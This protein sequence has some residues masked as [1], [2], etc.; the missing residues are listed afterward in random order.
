MTLLL[1]TANYP[2]L[3]LGVIT[4]FH[5]VFYFQGHASHYTI[6]DILSLNT[7]T[8]KGQHV[9]LWK[10]FRNHRHGLPRAVLKCDCCFETWV[11][12]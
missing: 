8:F 10:N 12:Y 9:E 3:L 7:G 4:V 11:H 6:V 2:T 5:Q 1:L